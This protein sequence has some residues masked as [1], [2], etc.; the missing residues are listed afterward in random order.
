MSELKELKN[1][2]NLSDKSIREKVSNIKNHYK[3]ISLTNQERRIL[4]LCGDLTEG[5]ILTVLTNKVILLN[6]LIFTYL[7]LISS[8]Q[9]WLKQTF[10]RNL[11]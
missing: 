1:I 3:T 5:A 11:V 9:W 4:S 10:S 7:P 6:Y 8:N 2:E